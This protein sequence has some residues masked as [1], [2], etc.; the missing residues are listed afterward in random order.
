MCITV[1]F[2]DDEW[3]LHKKII[4]FVHVSSHRGE[5]IAKAL[6]SFLLEWGL[7]NIFCVTV[8]ST[9]SNDTTIAYFKKKLLI[10]GVSS[11]RS[12]YVHM[13]CFAHILNLVVNE[14]LKDANLVIKR[15]R[16]AIRYAKNSPAR[17]RKFK[18]YSDLVCVEYKSSLSLNVPTRWN[19]TYLMLRRKVIS[20]F[21]RTSVQFYGRFG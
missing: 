4:S 9:S 18:E 2:I 7:M 15:V 14:G 12:K 6:E 13:R 20:S 17:L 16:E 10:W 3:R 8:D 11:V 1:H 19:S 5:Y 21:R